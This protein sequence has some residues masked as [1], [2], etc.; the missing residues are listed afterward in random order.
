[1]IHVLILILC[2]V[3][4]KQGLDED[5]QKVNGSYAIHCTTTVIPVVNE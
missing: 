3:W 5:E 1:M 2:G 4:C